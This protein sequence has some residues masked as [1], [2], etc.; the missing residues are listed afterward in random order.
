MHIEKDKLPRGLS[1]PVMTG[2]I[3][4]TLDEAG[5]TLDCTVIYSSSLSG[6]TAHFWPANPNVGFERLYLQV[7]AVSSDDV[8]EIRRRMIEFVLQA[9]VTWVRGLLALP[10]ASPVRREKQ[11]FH[12]HLYG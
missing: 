9:F 4:T 2:M 12:G 10:E 1:Y 6:F 3:A 11:E 7:G 5:I 8:A